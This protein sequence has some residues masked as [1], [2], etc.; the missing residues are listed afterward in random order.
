MRSWLPV[1]ACAV[2]VGTGSADTVP[3]PVIADTNIS[4]YPSE[5]A[6]NYGAA[7]HIRLKG[8]QMFGLFKFDLEPI[9][10]WRVERASLF[11]RAT[12]EDHLLRT[13][14]VYTV[15]CDWDEGQSAGE[16]GPGATFL[17]A[18]APDH[19]WGPGQDFLSV[20]FTHANTFVD[21]ADITRH[22]D[23]W[24]ELPVAPR[25]VHAMLVGASYGLLVTDE[26]GQTMANNDVYSREQA[27]SRPHLVVEGSPG[28]API[29]A[30][31][32]DL[33]VAADPEAA[34]YDSGGARVEWADGEGAFCYR[35]TVDGVELPPR[36]APWPAPPGGKQSLPLRGVL[37]SGQDV[38]VTVTPVNLT[39][40]P[41]P[42]AE[43]RGQA[44]PARPRPVPLPDPPATALTAARPTNST[45][46]SLTWC[47]DVLKVH[48]ISGNVLE[49]AGAERYG[50]APV[51]DAQPDG[52]GITLAAGRNEFVAA[53]L[54][55]TPTSVPAASLGVAATAL[56]GPGGS[57]PAPDLFRLWYVRD[58]EWMPE[59]CVPLSGPLSVPAVDNGVAG[60][61][62]QSVL[63]DFYVPHD[64]APGDY[65]GEVRVAA[66]GEEPAVMP[67]LLRVAPVTLPDR[68]SFVLEL[69]SY[70]DVSGQY[71]VDG[72]SAEYAA[73]EREYHRLA[74]QHRANWDPLPYSQASNPTPCM[75]PPLTGTGAQARIADWTAWDARYGP[76]LDGS[77]FA[78]LPRA[79][80]PVH[81]MYLPFC[82][83]W[84]ASI[85]LYTAAVPTKEYPQLV[86]DHA[87]TAPPIEQAFPA[88]YTDTFEAVL[89][90]YRTHIERR[91]CD[92]T[93]LQLYMNDKYYFKD[94]KQ[95]G[96]GTSWW[97]LDE[98]MHRDDWLALR[99]YALMMRQATD[100]ST[101]PFVSRGDISRPQWQPSWMMS[102]FDLECVAGE[103]FEHH[104]L[105]MDLQR[106]ARAAGRPI[107]FWHYG[108][109]NDVGRSNLECV[110]WALSAYLAGAD[111]ILPWNTIGSD[112]SYERPD[113]TAIL[114]PGR[115]FGIEGPVA[116]LRLKAMRRGAQDCE[117]LNMLATA[118][119][120]DRA[121]L[122]TLVGPKLGLEAQTVQ[123]YA[124]DAGT[125]RFDGLSADT[126]GR[127]RESLR[128][129]VATAP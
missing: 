68:L 70:G 57:L 98:P 83:G 27:A 105:C 26:K 80:V 66:P 128:A 107:V 56:T 97:L 114:Y 23:G 104:G 122:R 78:D 87:M 8:I 35:V 88:L 102:L 15:A 123:R 59:V 106:E 113:A 79:G 5:R 116:S 61:R 62:N 117:Y 38:T 121:D 4:E 89:K 10:G 46:V 96:R 55:V 86:I 65:S 72:T 81:S 129:A 103:L 125:L 84:P 63:L 54:V 22:P 93:W 101:A 28:Q 42:A 19:G 37:Q 112:S 126:F 99:F 100:G 51:A 44:S 71:G 120:L 74:H 2:A 47:E 17:R 49:I 21:Y 30:P 124:E 13:L 20:S 85:S 58:G 3:L 6:F 16:D 110:A 29:P 118:R 127:L 52:S 73:I 91:G 34:T 12:R 67:V 25:A 90:D 41:G 7:S 82:E 69:N 75:V 95:G 108:T 11:L 18:S 109:C 31:V 111:G 45:S 53:T 94:P 43:A 32:T 39:G 36:L 119:G 76:L 115:R 48:P 60:Q 9:R 24:V 40:Q 33:S 64:A 1:L 77:A 50:A 14:G 92:Q